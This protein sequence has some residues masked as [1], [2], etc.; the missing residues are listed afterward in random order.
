MM[1]LHTGAP[2]WLV[3]NGMG[4]LYPAL[5]DDARCD[6]VVVGAG[7]TGALVA[8]ALCE[9]GVD[10]VVID[11]REP[12]IGSTAASTALVL[13]ETDVELAPLVDKV[14]EWNAVRAWTLAREAITG[15]EMVTS[16][17]PD[18]CDYARQSSLY[19]A[20]R[21]RHV[22]RLQRE[23]ALRRKL[24][25]DAEFL[26]GDEVEK[27]FCSPSH[28]AIRATGAATIDPLRL[29]NSCSRARSRVEPGSSPGPP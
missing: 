18:S 24:G 4:A 2:Y 6:V 20:S 5:A 7:I 12:G 26:D 8:D 1:D 21:R 13:Y 22:R 17:L 3:R 23:T 14:G 11:R 19:L 25:F 29:R 9:R 10:V 15:I 16:T 27:T 28:G